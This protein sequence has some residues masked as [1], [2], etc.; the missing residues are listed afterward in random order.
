M[1]QMS[2]IGRLNTADPISVYV[3]LDNL[4]WS[5][6]RPTPKA[7]TGINNATRANKTSL[8]N[9]HRATLVPALGTLSFLHVCMGHGTENGDFGAD[10]G[11]GADADDTVVNKQTVFRDLHIFANADIVSV[12]AGERSLDDNPLPDGSCC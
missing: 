7:D 12:V 2:H 10:P 1:I 6:I 4:S 5:H 8:F 11:T 9:G 3:R